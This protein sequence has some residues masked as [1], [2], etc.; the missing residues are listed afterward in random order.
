MGIFMVNCHIVWEWLFKNALVLKGEVSCKTVGSD[1][2]AEAV[3][4]YYGAY[5]K[6]LKLSRI[7]RKPPVA[8]PLSNTRSPNC[9]CLEHGYS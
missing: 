3:G 4:E 9:F 5:A 8:F 7:R 6:P 2:R 1:G